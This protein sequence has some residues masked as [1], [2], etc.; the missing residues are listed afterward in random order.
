MDKKKNWLKPPH[1]G[2]IKTDRLSRE[3]L[4]LYREKYSIAPVTEDQV[5]QSTLDAESRRPPDPI[6]LSP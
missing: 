4:E 5:P 6:P 3:E 1:G 2:W